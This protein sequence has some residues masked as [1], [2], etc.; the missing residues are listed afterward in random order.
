M[1]GK[2]NHRPQAAGDAGFDDGYLDE[3]RYDD[4]EFDDMYSDDDDALGDQAETRPCPSCGAEVYEDAEQCPVC[5]EYITFGTGVFEGRPWWW[6]VLG[7][8]AIAAML[9]SLL[10]I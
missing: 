1:P 6:I 5:G 7:L 10:V 3:D 4:A 2:R 8:L 9:F